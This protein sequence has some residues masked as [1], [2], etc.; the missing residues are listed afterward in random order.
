MG[1]F[2]EKVDQKD[3]ERYKKEIRTE[4]EKL[5]TDIASKVTDSEEES[6]QSA[7][8]SKTILAEI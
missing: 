2:D 5:S 1:M 6:R 8:K 4:L 3:F 7:E